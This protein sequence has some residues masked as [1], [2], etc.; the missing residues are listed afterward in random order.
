MK[1][2]YIDCS[3]GAAGDMISAA[4][5][6][7]MPDKDAA[8]EKLNSFG[9]KGVKYSLE[10]T[11][12]C[13][14]SA[15]RLSVTVNG[16]EESIDME[17]H[18]HAH[19]H[20]HGHHHGHTHTHEHSHTHTH[21][22][23]HE[24]RSLNDILELIESLY[25]DQ[26]VKADIASTYNLLAD[27]ESKAHG[28]S[29]SEVH[30]HEVGA[31]DA[32]ADIAAACS[33]MADLAPDEV[34]SSPINVGSGSVKCA[35]GIIS[36]PAPATAALLMGIPSYG[37][38]LCPFELCT[39]T[40]AALIR[41]FATRFSQQP[42]MTVTA[43]G[44][45]AGK[46]DFGEKAN[47]LRCTLGEAKLQSNV[48]TVFEIACNIDD[49]T[50]EDISFAVEKIFDSGALDVLTIPATMKKGRPGVILIA[51]CKNETHEAV[52][53]AIFTHTSTLGIR[54]K[55]CN[56][57]VLKRKIETVALP[58]G[59]KIRRK[60]SLRSQAAS[61]AKFEFDDLADVAKKLGKPISAVRT[62][63]EQSCKD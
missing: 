8:I 34:V 36:V 6:D 48:D 37:D 12:R 15:K 24:H 19:C 63:C 39:P 61:T 56:R 9:I 47:I 35:H 16:S 44:Y 11:S 32:I 10:T 1:T 52:V 5:L 26:K 50:G 30:F 17:E 53:E 3:M 41:K 55:E 62:M 38:N 58:D 14:I 40:G 54:E 43:I 46:K 22:H 13:G 2:L 59:T 7:L 49:M 33:L 18:H 60:I 28:R 29:V 31:L 25:L 21:S 42:A 57:R 4:L 45:G 27:A 20:D 23:S 51:L